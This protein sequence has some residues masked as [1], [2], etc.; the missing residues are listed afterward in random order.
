MLH[1]AHQTQRELGRED[2]GVLRLVFFQDV[3]LHRSAHCRQ[4][5]GPNALVDV[6]RQHLVAGDSEQQ[7]AEAVVTLGQLALVLRKRDTTL[8]RQRL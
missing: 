6:A 7:E 3:G 1:V 5:F 2:A 4:R 8:G